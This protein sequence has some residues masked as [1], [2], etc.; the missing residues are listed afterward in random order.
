MKRIKK[1]NIIVTL[2]IIFL[3]CCLQQIENP[4][5]PSAERGIIEGVVADS[6]NGAPI[7]NATVYIQG[8]NLRTTSDSQ[9][10]YRIENVPAGTQI[11]HAQASGYE[12]QSKSVEVRANISITVDFLLKPSSSQGN[13]YYVSPNGSDSNPGTRERP[14]ATPGYGS[15]QL[16]PGDTLVILRGK[17]ILKR[18]DDDIITP[19]SGNENAWI[20]IKGE[21]GN[22]PVLAGSE[23]LLTALNLSGVSYVKIENLEITHDPSVSGSSLFFRDGIEILGSP[24]VHIVLKDLYIHHIDEFGMNIQDVDDLQILNCR[25]EYCGFGA[26]GGPS[27]EHG[28]WK[29]VKIQNCKLSYSGHYYQGGDGSNRP[30]DRPDGFGIEPSAGP[31]LIEDT[32]AEHN[33]GDGIDSKAENT[34]IKKC[35]VGN[36]SCDGVKLLGDRSRIE[37]TLIYG[38]GDGKNETTPWSAIVI[39][40]V[41]KANSTFEIVNVA[42]DDA[43]GG[44]Y[45][46]YVQY[47]VN[48]PVRVLIR[49]TIFSGRGPNS[50]IYIGSSVTLSADHNLFYLPQSGGIILEHGS[51]FYTQSNIGELGEGNIYG[52]PLF[53]SPSWGSKGDYHLQNGSPA[54][55]KGTSN[56]APSVDLEGKPRPQ[57]S[58]FDIGAYEK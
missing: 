45:L 52:D 2:L 28:G 34:I 30:Y 7:P 46:F 21:D 26:L 36:N 51:K 50:H 3:T 23:N 25:I 42:I 6:S 20:I 12:T 48:V 8:S 14:W 19:P 58:G 18:Y 32:I 29:N 40:Q 55:D 35:I 38:R 43:L 44:N 49:N 33:Y 41:E 9:G 47:G 39:D 1:K 22:R 11:V 27:P 5:A 31:I 13:V 54:I 57:G 17:Y 37:N 53:L 16:R 4:S 24:A 56:G 15:R 10:R